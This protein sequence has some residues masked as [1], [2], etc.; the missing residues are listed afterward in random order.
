MPSSWSWATA[1][2]MS[3]V[4]GVTVVIGPPGVLSDDGCAPE[5]TQETRDPFCGMQAPAVGTS[6]GMDDSQI[7]QPTNDDGRNMQDPAHPLPDEPADESGQGAGAGV[8]DSGGGDSG[9]GD[10]G[11]G[12]AAAVTAA[13]ATAAASRTSTTSRTRTPSR[14]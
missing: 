1:L 11:G 14:R 2:V 3:W 13:A 7:S 8:A 10:S 9:G 6:R 5:S 12:A 4:S